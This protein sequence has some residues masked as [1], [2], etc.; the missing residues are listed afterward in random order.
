MSGTIA[1]TG[2]GGFIGS[3]VVARLHGAGARVRALLGPPGAPVH[4]PADGVEA[5]RCDIT[6]HAALEAL[7][8]GADVVVHAAGPPSVRASFDEPLEF[9]RAH[10]LGT[11]C[12]LEAMRRTGVRRIVHVSSAEI[13]GRPL[14]ELVREDDPP[15]PRSPYGAA[16]LAAETLVR[17]AAWSA[18][19]SGYSLRPFS[20]YG[21]RMAGTSLVGTILAQAAAGSEILVEDL[22]A[23]RDYCYVRDLA[24]AVAA[25]C[26]RHAAG[27]V[28]LNVASG[29]ATSV[30]ML[31]SALGRALGRPLSVRQRDG[32]ARPP[33]AE[34]PR[35]VAD[36]RAAAEVLGWRPRHG[37]EAGFADMLR[38][39]VAR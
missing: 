2:G 26:E 7:F 15:A 6:E 3:A 36:V 33:N 16:K 13:Y 18:G 23:V 25:A 20:V 34:I 24:D 14:G 27:V 5:I 1:V 8:A 30:P 35:L 22:G 32:R 4:P 31:V 28:P 37:I 38:Q 12:V 10:V 9:V 19:L 17:A 21:P 29:A 11:A 39:A